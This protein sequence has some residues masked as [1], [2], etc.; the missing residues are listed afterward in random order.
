MLMHRE[1]KMGM[2]CRQHHQEV[3]WQLCNYC[4]RVEQM[5]MHRE[6]NMRM[7]CRQH[8]GEVTWQLCNCCCRVEQMLMCKTNTTVLNP[9]GSIILIQGNVIIPILLISN[10]Y[11][12]LV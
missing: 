8:Y 11:L 1:V 6:V 3:T 10:T 7:H 9:H 2:H 4:C 12:Y 5:S